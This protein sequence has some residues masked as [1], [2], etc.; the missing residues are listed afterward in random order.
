LIKLQVVVANVIF[1]LVGQ[2]QFAVRVVHPQD[3]TIS[4]EKVARGASFPPTFGFQ[5]GTRRWRL[6]AGRRLLRLI[7]RISP[8]GWWVLAGV[9][10]AA[11]IITLRFVLEHAK[12]GLKR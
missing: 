2:G 11:A 8:S 12:V 6:H 3:V 4:P 7:P 9:L 5:C 1:F 10:L